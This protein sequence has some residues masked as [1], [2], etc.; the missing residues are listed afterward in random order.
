MLFVGVY[1]LGESYSQQQCPQTLEKTVRM[2]RGENVD[3]DCTLKAWSGEL[4]IG[5]PGKWT[6]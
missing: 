5:G 3:T 6:V 1:Q 2:N 4:L